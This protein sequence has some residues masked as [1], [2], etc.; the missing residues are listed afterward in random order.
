VAACR[1]ITPA[2]TA[3][4]R[5]SIQPA[6]DVAGDA[7]ASGRATAAAR[8]PVM[9]MASLHRDRR[10]ATWTPVAPFGPLATAEGPWYAGGL[11][12]IEA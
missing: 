9:A 11:A 1:M 3:T 5:L 2:I 12:Q 7:A 6:R 8:A 10:R 4:R